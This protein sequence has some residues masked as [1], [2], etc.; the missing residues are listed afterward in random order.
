MPPTPNLPSF[1]DKR[2][3]LG[4]R[5]GERV[6][7][8]GM[9]GLYPESH[10]VKD[11]AN[12]LYNKINPINNE[13]VRWKY[14]HPEVAQYTGKI[15]GLKHFD[16]QFF[17]VH[18][19][20]S[21][22]MDAM[23][24][25]LLEQSYQAIY[26]A[27]ICPEELSG[28]K[29]G[30]YVGSC[31]SES[32][33]GIFYAA[34]TRTGFGI[35][36]GS[37][38]MFANRI[39]YW[40][41]AKGPSMSIDE[42]CC[43][44]TEALNQAYLAIKHGECEAAIVGGS[45]LCLHPQ[46]TIHYGRIINLSM[47]GKTKS[48]D[49][50]ADGCAK[51]EAIN[52]L[53]L[54]KAEDALRIYA[55]VL[56]VKC[57]YLS[58][59]EHETKGHRYG[60][61]RDPDNMA[62][63]IS[64]FYEEANVSPQAIEYVEACGSATPEVDKAELEAIEKAY[65]THNNRRQPLLV[66]SVMSNI[67][68]CEAASGISAIT[69]VL[70]G[71]HSGKLAGN[72]NCD[73]PRNDVAALRD[74]RMR[75]LTD[76]HSFDRSYTA[77]NS[78]SLTGVNAH[79]LLYGHYKA[80]DA[81]RYKTNI[82]YLVLVSGRQETSVNKILLD[83]KSRPVDPE[84]IALLHNI[85]KTRISGHLGRGFIL[86]DKS[87]KDETICVHEKSN[88]FDDSK[89]PLWFVYSGMGSQWAG[90]GAQLMRIPLFAAAIE[91]CR[92]VLE[93]KGLD[94]VHII[95]SP[96][97]TIFDNILNSFVGIAAIQIGLTDI[98]QA[99]EISPDKMIGHS[100]GELGCAYADGCFT[101][102]EMILSAYSRGLVS[103]QTPFIRGSMAAVGLGFER[104]SKM[105]PPEI[106][107][108]C[109]NGP[110]SSTISGPADIMKEFVAQLTAKGIFAKE[111][112]CSNIAYH[113]RYIAEAGPGLLK[114]LGEVITSPKVRSS[115]WVSTSVPQE[116]WNDPIAK[117]SS[118]EYHTNNLL[119]SVLFEETS[120]LI[121]SNAVVVEIAPHSL[122]HAILKRSLPESCQHVSLTRRGH[123]NNAVFLLEAL[124]DLF[125]LGYNP[126]VQALYPK[127]EFPV[128]T[129]TPMLSH[130]VEWAHHEPWIVPLIVS[131]KNKAA[132]SCNHII[133]MHDDDHNYLR[134]HVVKG[135]TSYP[136]AAALVIVW[137][138]LAMVLGVPKK[139]LSVKFRDVHL[140]LQPVLQDREQL[141]LYVT[142]QRGRGYFE[143][144]NNNIKI[145]TGFIISEMNNLMSVEDELKLV[146]D[147]ELKSEEI[148]E[149]LYA[150]DYNYM[151][152]FRSIHNA[153]MSLTEAHLLWQNNWVTLIDGMIQLNA[154]RRHQ[155]SVSQPNFIRK[156]VIDV[157]NHL[158]A[159]D[160]GN[161]IPAKVCD[162]MNTTRCGGVLIENIKF[163]DMASST[164]EQVVFKKNVSDFSTNNI[165]VIQ[166]V[167]YFKP[168]QETI[169][170]RNKMALEMTRLGDTNFTQW[171]EVAKSNHQGI[172]VTVQ[173]AGLSDAYIKKVFGVTAKESIDN[174]KM[175]EYDFSGVT[176]RKER[177]MG[178]VQDE[179]IS[180]HIQAKPELLWP[181]PDHWT[182]EEAATV[183][184]AYCLAFYCLCI[185][186]RFYRGI[187]ILVH[188][189][190]GALGQAILSIALAHDCDIYTTVSSTKK[191]RFLLK[192]FPELK[193]DHI[194]CSR[195]GSFKDMVLN[196]T[197]GEG[198][199]IVIN[200]LK[201]SIRDASFECCK[202]FA[203]VVDT[204]LIV[205]DEDYIFRL[206]SVSKS[207]TY[208]TVQFSTLFD[209]RNVEELKRL[210]LMVSEGIA[211][212]YVRPLSR[213]VYAA[214][215]AS[216]A[217]RLQASGRHVGCVLLHLEE[218]ISCT[219]NRSWE[220]QGVQLAISYGNLW[221]EDVFN[222]LN[223]EK[224]ENVEG[225][226]CIVNSDLEI[227]N[228]NKRLEQLTQAI[229]RLNW[230]IKY[231][232]VIDTKDCTSS[233]L[234]KLTEPHNVFITIN[235][236]SLKI[237]RY[238]LFLVTCLNATCRRVFLFKY[239]TSLL[240]VA[241]N[242]YF[243]VSHAIDAIEKAI[244]NKQP[245]IAAHRTQNSLGNL[246]EELANLA[247]F[248]FVDGPL[249]LQDATLEELGMDPSKSEI[250]RAY[251]R[252]LHN[253]S[254]D[255]SDIPSL[256]IKKIWEL[257]GNEE[258]EMFTETEDLK[259]FL[260]HID[261]DELLATAEI[262]LLPTLTTSSTTTDEFDVNETYLCVVPGVEGLHV[263]FRE[264]C[265]RI[266]VPALVL[267][268]GVDKPQETIQEI[269][270]R[271]AKILLK[272]T[273][274]KKRFYLLG[275]E[276]GV[277]VALEMAA[278]LEDSGLNG[279]IFCIGGTP[280]EVLEK[281]EEKLSK[282]ETEESLQ[283][284]VASHMFK[285][286]VNGDSPEN[287]DIDLKSI[288][289]WK[290]KVSF[291]VQMLLGRIDHSIQYAKEIIEA[292]YERIVQV[293]RYQSQPRPLRSLL[294]TIRPWTSTT[295]NVKFHSLQSHSQQ[296][297][298]EYQLQVPL[299]YAAQDMRCAAIVN[300]HLDKDIL[301]GFDKKNLCETY[302]TKADS[303][304][305]IESMLV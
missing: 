105:V 219:Q 263:R 43:S 178:I 21:N 139:Q 124:G 257:A 281:F 64:T 165:D 81:R 154:L 56:H 22:N 255:E 39:S 158:R 238:F 182:L 102:E 107:I 301:E 62:N 231:F 80:K 297:V 164:K 7:I 129:T 86:L 148:Y 111:V 34:N 232:A 162:V 156:I 302:Q 279:T 208:N 245:L 63:F 258:N 194:G 283:S 206:H 225:I 226:Y 103:V 241:N 253:V 291:C 61:Y 144:M 72:L 58:N 171:I 202:L 82:P 140:Y 159:V 250:V 14:E 135:K 50:E 227:E 252:D 303:F 89:R 136:F 45:N 230:P 76:H 214:E 168:I 157:K 275:Y 137:D 260:T 110:D 203:F 59:L 155:D 93:P 146:E 55:E 65:C 269:A 153:N 115:R 240:Q 84:E 290:E 181:V 235:L 272:K 18:Y 266:K 147:L 78:I 200:S 265:E 217:L 37:K 213:V 170:K 38:S 47:D 16:A 183:P 106:E 289:T 4:D 28:K 267:Q 205:D 179:S 122:L 304:V 44:S 49:T 128:S 174:K 90:M 288:P 161:V 236:P 296:K 66:G 70:L 119:N 207:T 211:R 259:T 192:L 120:R 75:I 228:I 218:D 152:E 239:F 184:L 177:V 27:G 138:T 99:L 9:S 51:S 190:S 60:F 101:A 188:D 298:V 185:K 299:A 141:R 293:R 256:S 305:F 248:T 132:S 212:G 268:P 244:C 104:M 201:G 261:P 271:Y 30:V 17:K 130:L 215:D 300:R 286:L 197:K 151:D 234:I 33:K 74:G 229:Q 20:L 270:Q 242:K 11:L 2:S 57:L 284:A 23:G 24:R 280:Q 3:L 167:K 112:P 246:L 150:R 26:D 83:L 172:S 108:A 15:P 94:I 85:H 285:L 1:S 220:N 196:G 13:N 216:R 88:Y 67:G 149:L 114:Y 173:Y 163:H 169:S 237:V 274:L 282:F 249:S 31:I 5:S 195:D 71:Y 180:T 95:T 224:I 123:P 109:H 69:K 73:S 176:N 223:S 116:K 277:L 19:R 10:N 193:E 160:G 278:I 36:G 92:C 247:D 53:F 46:S 262:V 222:L 142:I 204:S 221:N 52:V 42:G 189:G 127:V 233:N 48:F 68:Y 191:K 198:C 97:K 276:S 294:V 254:L 91:K 251:L 264:L 117:Y 243:P 35:S 87:Q 79:V 134:G 295:N 40:L 98:L 145:A 100:V 25:K 209:I 32:E 166:G 292:V 210:Q 118:A 187:S 131:E 133:S 287:L 199:Y 126:K 77:I 186:A 12:I 41:N 113:S 54:Q 29:I 143:V 121:P 6:V 273:Q 125:M 96:D 8:S 175:I